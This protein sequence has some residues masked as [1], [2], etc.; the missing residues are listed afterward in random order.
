MRLEEVK[1]MFKSHL[2]MEHEHVTTYCSVN[3]EPAIEWCRRVPYRNGEPTRRS[4]TR[5]FVNG[6][7]FRRPQALEKYLEE[8]GGLREIQAKGGAS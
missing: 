2:N 1:G 6:K 3:C 4:S 7:A 8:I 5:Y